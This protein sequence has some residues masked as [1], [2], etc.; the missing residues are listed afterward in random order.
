MSI[1]DVNYNYQLHGVEMVYIPQGDFYIGDG[2]RGG[3]SGWGFSNGGAA[4]ALQITSAIQ[5]AGLNANQY[6]VSSYA[7]NLLN[8]FP[9]GYNAFYTMKYEISQEQY[10]AFLNS[11]TYAQQANRFAVSQLSAAGT[12]V[13]AGATNC[14]NG[15]R[16]K[17]SGVLS[18]IPAVVGC[19]L[20]GD[21]TFDEADD[22]QNLPC[23]WLSWADLMAYLDWS[24][25]R[26]MTEFE[27]EKICRGTIASVSLEYAWGSTTILEANAGALTNAGTANEIS[28]SAGNGLCAYNA[29]TTT[30]RGPL[31][32][33]FAPTA[34]TTRTQAGATYYGVMDMSG[35]VNEQC[36]GGYNG[37]NYGTFTNANG[38]GTLTVAG[39]AN[40][41]NWPPTGGGNGGGGICRGGDWYYTQGYCYIS[42]RGWMTNN[43]NQGR[44][45]VA[46][47]RGVRSF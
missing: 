11:L 47:G 18:N 9:M 46:G 4:T 14:R 13:I 6:Q 3:G 31:R 25:L 10:V 37:Y 16:I 38:D 39:V 30:N 28:T 8:T 44:W 12:L 45:N 19:D 29:A 24:A 1:T 22:G 35:N 17:T 34:T 33:G 41:A 23:N 40:T 15:I 21:G 43:T 32:C 26:P 20:D 5:T 7:S 27:F 42:S 2:S 36:I